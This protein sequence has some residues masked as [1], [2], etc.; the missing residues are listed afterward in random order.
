[1]KIKDYLA[2]I[3][4]RGGQTK[5][6]SKVRGDSDYYKRISAKAAQARKAKAAALYHMDHCRVH[7]DQDAKCN[8]GAAKR[9][10]RT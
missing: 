4:R 10:E 1:M 3:G 6:K 9:K 8:C 5:G 7:D 2:E